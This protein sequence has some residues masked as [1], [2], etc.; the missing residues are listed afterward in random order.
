MDANVE[1]LKRLY[2]ASLGMVE[3]EPDMPSH[4]DVEA[5]FTRAMT[6]ARAALEAAGVTVPELAEF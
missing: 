2:L 4:E 5:T 3:S 6:D 1:L